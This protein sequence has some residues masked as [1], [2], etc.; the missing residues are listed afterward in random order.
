MASVNIGETLKEARLQKNIS[1]DELQQMTKI[2]K[3]Y[4]EIIE[5]NDF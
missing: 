3:R 2:Q 4:L 5:Q 1:I